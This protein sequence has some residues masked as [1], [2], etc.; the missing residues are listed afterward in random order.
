VLV[1]TQQHFQPNDKIFFQYK[2]N[3]AYQFIA[4][5]YDFPQEAIIPITERLKDEAQVA[6]LR[7]EHQKN[8]QQ[9]LRIWFAVTFDNQQHIEPL[10]T[11]LT[12]HA[13]VGE[14]HTARGAA[15]FTLDFPAATGPQ[16]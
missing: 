16:P 1:H 14:L 15:V 4:S 7:S 3:T 10:R 12:N 13:T 6:L 8:T 11:A 2:D 5:R 9:P